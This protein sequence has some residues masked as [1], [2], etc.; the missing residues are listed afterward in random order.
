[1][2]ARTFMNGARLVKLSNTLGALKTITE[3][4]SVAANLHY[5]MLFP[6]LCPCPTEFPLHHVKHYAKG[7]NIKKE[8]GKSKIIINESEI[9][10]A[11]DVDA[12]K[13]QMQKAIEQLKEDFVK[14]LSLRSAAGSI[15][16]IPVNVDGKEHTLQELAQIVRKNPKTVVINMSVFPQAIPATLKA[17]EKSGMNLNPQQ[18]G[19]TI[20]VPVPKVTKEYREGLA[21]GAK[22]LFVKCKTAIRDVQM[23]NIKQLKRKEKLSQD[24]ARSIENQIIAIADGYIAGAEKILEDKTNE[25]IGKE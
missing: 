17:L 4:T 19:T 11:V 23:K 2:F 25:L 8:K 15:E 13:S 7:K 12:L 14:N 6:R 21:K 9:S 3:C 1:M 16:T 5:S 20:F 10:Q 24:T 22:Q 18:D